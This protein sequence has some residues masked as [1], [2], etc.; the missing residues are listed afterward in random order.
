MSS[1]ALAREADSAVKLSVGGHEEPAPA[2]AVHLAR[3]NVQVLRGENRYSM[4][5]ISLRDI[6]HSRLVCVEECAL[7]VREGRR[8]GR[9]RDGRGGEGRGGEG[10]GGEGR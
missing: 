5:A 7:W 3:E 4:G 6:S 2:V 10:R 9:G 8:R 1:A